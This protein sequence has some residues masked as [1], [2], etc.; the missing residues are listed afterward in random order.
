LPAS[1]HPSEK[2]SILL[3]PGV[4]FNSF[5]LARLAFF[6]LYLR[7]SEHFFFITSEEAIEEPKKAA[8]KSFFLCD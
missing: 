5:V 2:N 7:Q 3:R 6:A 1:Q 4:A 8:P